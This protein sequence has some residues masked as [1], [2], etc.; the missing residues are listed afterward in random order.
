MIE[1]YFC[2]IIIKICYIII[3][4]TVK[5]KKKLKKK[6]V[7]IL[8]IILILLVA[9]VIVGIII[10]KKNNDVEKN[11]NIEL[12]GDKEITLEYKSEYQDQGAKANF[13]DMDI[14]NSIEVDNNLDLEHIGE[15]FYNYKIKYKDSIKETKRT[16]KVV[17]NQ[18]PDIKLTGREDITFVAG[19]E[20]RELG[21]TAS[22]DYDGDLSEKIEVDKSELDLNKSG[23]YNVKYKVKDSSGNENEIVRQVRVVDKNATSIPVLNY[24]FFYKDS[25]D[26]CNEQLCLRVDRFKEQLEYLRDNGFYTLTIQEFVSWMYGEI[27]LPEKSI[28]LTIDDGGKGTSKDS[29]NYLISTLEEYK[30]HGTLFLITGW[31]PISN[32]ESSYLDVQSHTHELHYENIKGCSHRSKVNC[33]SYEALVNDLKSSIEVVKDTSSFCFPFYDYTESSIKAVKEVGFKTAF[34]GGFRKAKR[35]DD[36][37]KIPRFVVYDNT[38]LSTFKNY[39]N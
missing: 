20:Y 3:G 9:L 11:L 25:S 15:Y 17:D 16:I 13:K 38:S 28:L 24:H 19:T 22:D 4:D 6:N 7:A 5:K 21:A 23:I 2:L 27:E 31:W 39:I 34:V 30:M 32:Y 10:L 14:S 33:I 37:Y 35:S 18:K 1:L 8:C 12:I 36:K 29:G 26:K